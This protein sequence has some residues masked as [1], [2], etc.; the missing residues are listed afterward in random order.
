MYIYIYIYI[1]IYRYLGHIL[2]NRCYYDY[3]HYIWLQEK[4]ILKQEIDNGDS[5]SLE[6]EGDY[7]IKI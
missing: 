4:D 2:F 7:N 3:L 5:F 1:Y 6:T